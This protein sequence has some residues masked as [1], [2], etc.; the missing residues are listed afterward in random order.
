MSAKIVL[1]KEEAERMAVAYSPRRF[2]T[3]VQSTA[4]DF[5]AY[6]N[7]KQDGQEPSFRIDKIVAE[8]TGIAELERLSIE[9]KVER[10]A[11]SRIKELQ[12]QAYHEAYQLGFDEGRESAF[13][14]R[15]TELV[16]SLNQLADLLGSIERL[17]E[18]LVANNE[19]QIVRLV[20]E[21]AKRVVLRELSVSQDA[22]LDVMKQ[23]V[24]SAQ[25]EE[26][27]TI[28]VSSDDY[29]FIENIKT[30]LGKDFDF[31]QRAKLEASEEVS[32]GGCIVET[33]YG[34][35]NATVEQRLDKLWATISEKLPK[36]GDV[37]KS[38]AVK[39][40]ANDEVPLIL[41]DDSGSGDEGNGQGE[42]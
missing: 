27:I 23:A 11:L 29:A 32:K 35:V 13:V 42:E 37:I 18:D 21:M 5:V 8:Q 12:E 38:E 34:V 6:R 33:N 40:S 4:R 31:L 36:V 19:R 10:E 14:E 25:S 15:K 17:K 7:S 22:V 2:P 39:S 41:P 20:F 9:E 16:R 30:K 3:T 26:T 24:A 28:R 1:S